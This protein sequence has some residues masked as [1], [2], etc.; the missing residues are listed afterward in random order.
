[1]F[2]FSTSQ[3]NY[4]G[5]GAGAQALSAGR[6]IVPKRGEQAGD[7]ARVAGAMRGL[8]AQV[9][10]RAA[11]ELAANKAQPSQAKRK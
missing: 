5:L 7:F 9:N 10:N 4:R 8:T 11:Q 1:M 6:F 3:S 2:T